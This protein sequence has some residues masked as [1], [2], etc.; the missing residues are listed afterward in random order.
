MRLDYILASSSLLAGALRPTRFKT[1]TDTPG[2]DHFPV[3]CVFTHRN[4]VTHL[5]LA[6]MFDHM[7]MDDLDCLPSLQSTL[8]VLQ[9]ALN[10]L[11]DNS[12]V[13]L[14]F[15]DEKVRRTLSSR[16]L[17]VEERP[18][19]RWNARNT[20]QGKEYSVVAH[21]PEHE[22]SRVLQTLKETKAPWACLA[23]LR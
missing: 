16:G 15:V 10:L 11:D 19:I 17:Q 2:S 22:A 8:R 5:T 21:P 1:H 20:W 7:V 9:P 23:P 4:K 6:N 18:S 3:S 14:P 13:F 12:A